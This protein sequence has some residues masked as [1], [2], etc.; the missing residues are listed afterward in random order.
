A[1]WR[2]GWRMDRGCPV[3]LQ[4]WRRL[5][6]RAGPSAGVDGYCCDVR[7]LRVDEG[8]LQMNSVPGA[9]NES[10]GLQKRVTRD[11]AGAAAIPKAAEER[12][13]SQLMFKPGTSMTGGVSQAEKRVAQGLELE[14]QAVQKIASHPFHAM[15][16]GFT[17]NAGSLENRV[18]WYAHEKTSC[19]VVLE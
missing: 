18:L 1:P 6:R 8:A 13:R 12:R 4:F 3:R 5:W 15:V 16:E 14:R 10:E 7:C 9:N 19:N 11:K 17:K 2:G